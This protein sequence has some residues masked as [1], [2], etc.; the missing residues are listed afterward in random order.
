MSQ[1][2]VRWLA[3]IP[4]PAKVAAIVITVLLILALCGRFFASSTASYSPWFRKR[5]GALVH[6][7]LQL[8]QQASQS[9]GHYTAIQ[10]YTAAITTLDVLKFLVPEE[11]IQANTPIRISDL[12]VE[13]VDRRSKIEFPLQSSSLRSPASFAPTGTGVTIAKA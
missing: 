3:L 6:T 2:A 8:G 13:L 1:G 10:N 4:D 9:T 7:A 11:A 12:M 5:M